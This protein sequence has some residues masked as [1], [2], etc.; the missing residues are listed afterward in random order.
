MQD[1]TTSKEKILKRIRKA[2]IHKS[3]Q[4]IGDVNT[5]AEIFTTS[6][7]PIELQFAQNF[8]NVNGKFVFCEDETDFLENFKS[9]VQDNQW[10]GLFSFEPAIQQL[11]TKIALPFSSDEHKLLEANIGLTFCECLIARTGSILISSKQASGRRLP[12]YSNYHVV[13]AYTS[14]L[15]LHV[16]DGLKHIREKYTNQLPSMI[17]TITGPSRTADIE[18]TL[19]Q[20]AHGPKE[21]FVFL[22]DD[23]P[24]E[25]NS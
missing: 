6:E 3:L 24:A 7:E 20:G 4:E 19:V 2:L 10:E 15:F 23:T 16:K 8:V 12:I 21:I 25:S 5:E 22:I 14:Q 13:I 9:I 11:L 17:S 18:K 1:S